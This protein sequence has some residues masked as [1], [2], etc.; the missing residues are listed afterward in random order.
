MDYS[1]LDAARHRRRLAM[2]R[3]QTSSGRSHPSGAGGSPAAVYGRVWAGGDVEAGLPGLVDGTITVWLVSFD[4]PWDD[5]CPAVKAT[6]A[7]ITRNTRPTI[8]LQRLFASSG[9]SSGEPFW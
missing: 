1:K 7:T 2:G 4:A 9:G 6:A 5:L 3:R 8:T